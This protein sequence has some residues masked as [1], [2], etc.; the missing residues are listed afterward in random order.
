MLTESLTE[1]LAPAAT[2]RV[3]PSIFRPRKT[4]RSP[5]PQR[6]LERRRTLGTGSPLP[7]Q[8]RQHF[9]VGEE[10]ALSIVGD[11]VRAK[12]LCDICI[13]AIAARAAVSRG[14]TKRALHLAKTLGLISIDVMHGEPA[15]HR[16]ARRQRQRCERAP[17]KARRDL[18][19]ERPRL[20]QPHRPIRRIGHPRRPADSISASLLLSR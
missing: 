18:S 13:D 9:T 17:L 15:P 8:F 2:P 20:R 16:A 1:S 12:G 7:P 6:S 14:T 11:E 19:T 10:A 4:Q 3:R 5:D